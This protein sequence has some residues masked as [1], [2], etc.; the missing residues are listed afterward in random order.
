ME[1]MSADLPAR[2]AEKLLAIGLQRIGW[3]ARNIE[4]DLVVGRVKVELHRFDGR[5]LYLVADA[6]G[7]AQIERWHRRAIVTRYRGGPECDGFED[8]FLGRTRCEG[9][10]AALRSLASYVAENPCPGRLAIGAEDVRN[11]LR[12]VMS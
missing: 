12:L 3:E 8:Q 1:R 6:E 11:L 10:R 5:W 7:C 4:I 9:P 2:D